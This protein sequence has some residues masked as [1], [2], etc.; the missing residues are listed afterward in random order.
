LE[1]WIMSLSAL[2]HRLGHGFRSRRR[3]RSPAWGYRPRL[4]ALEDRTVPSGGYVFT[5]F[6][7]PSAGSGPG[8]GIE[9]GG[10]NDRG[11]IVGATVV[12]LTIT[13]GFLLSHGQFT[14]IDD[15]NAV[16]GTGASDINASGQIVGLYFDANNVSHGYLLS[17]GQFTTID[18]PNAGTGPGQGTEVQG[19]NASGQMVGTYVD[20]G[21]VEHGFLL[22]GGRFT[23][24]DDPNAGAGFEQGTEAAGINAAGQIVGKYFDANNV[25]HGFLLSGGQFTTLDDPNA[26]TGPL[27]GTLSGAINN[28][29]Q[30]VGF[31][32][33]ATGLLHGF[34]LSDGQY[35]TLDDPNAGTNASVG[36][37]GTLASKI[38]DSGRIVGWYI[39]SNLAPH[40]F[41]ARP[42]H[43]DSL[44]AAADNLMPASG[45]STLRGG[46][47]AANGSGYV[48][49]A[50]SASANQHGG[51]VEPESV[52]CLIPSGP[53]APGQHAGVAGQDLF[54]QSDVVDD[55]FGA[56]L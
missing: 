2:F 42:D 53:C 17:H 37:E 34:L 7:D 15:P 50:P 38:T 12:N 28:H 25:N 11:Q 27:Q 5:N 47:D 56:G 44:V 41:V 19:I 35:T 8:Q 16:L 33:D 54:G 36:E 40:G 20:A 30:I 39:D 1:E 49:S 26:G 14:T 32:A 23:T 51:A 24:I 55:L 45:G 9:V 21:S 10:I 4:E 52:V 18:D 3:R 13:H 43:C 31:F 48:V 46:V 22:S 6:D 29:G